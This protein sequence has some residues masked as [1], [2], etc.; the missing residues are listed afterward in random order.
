MGDYSLA[1]ASTWADEIRSNPKYDF[2]APSHYTS[3]KDG[4]NYSKERDNDIIATLKKLFIAIKKNKN[5]LDFTDK[6]KIALVVHLVGDLHQPLHVGRAD[7]WGGNRVRVGWF[8]KS[9][10]LHKV[11]D[12]GVID[13]IGLSYTELANFLNRKEKINKHKDPDFN[14]ASAIELINRTAKESVALRPV[15]YNFKNGYSTD[16]KTLE[17]LKSLFNSYPHAD[18]LKYKKKANPKKYPDLSYDYL[19]RA[20]PIVEQRLLQAG[21]R[22]AKI[23]NQIL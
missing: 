21:L 8:G 19:Y 5:F 3:V 4:A 15:A 16:F 6:Q 20:R 1:E 17:S 12:S 9:S 22:L 13:Q 23:L 14:Q 7:D 2:F 11:W 10:N 18:S